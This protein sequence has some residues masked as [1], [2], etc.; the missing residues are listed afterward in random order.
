[1]VDIVALTAWHR[2]DGNQHAVRTAKRHVLCIKLIE[3]ELGDIVA[4]EHNDSLIQVTH[5]VW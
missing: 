2:L 3:I 1:M 4:C 5:R